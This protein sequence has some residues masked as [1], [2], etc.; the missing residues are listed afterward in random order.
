MGEA[1][2]EGEARAVG[3]GRTAG[4][5]GAGGL[6]ARAGTGE[7]IGVAAPAG[8]TR[9]AGGAELETDA[10]NVSARLE[11]VGLLGIVALA[12]VLRFVDLPTRGMWDSDQGHDMLVL[13]SWVIDGVVPLLG[14]PTSTGGIHHGALYYWLLAPAAALSRADPVA[15]TAAI[16]LFG[17]A[18]VAATWWLARTLGGPVAGLVAGVLMAV[19]PSSIEESTFIWNPTLV[20]V[21]SAIAVAA[22]WRAWTTRRARWWPVAAAGQAVA[23]QAHVLAAILLVPLVALVI[24]DLRRREPGTER[25]RAVAAAVAGLGVIALSYL[26]LLVHE[27]G[28]GFA[29]P[30]RL[31]GFAASGEGAASGD[32]APTIILRLVIVAIRSLS[33]PFT[34]LLTGAPIPA[35]LAATAIVLI[36]GWRVR[37]AVP[38]ERSA[39]VWFAATIAWSIAAL[40]VAAPSLATI[41]PG[42]PN[43]HYHAFL[44]TIVFAIAGL[45]AASVWRRG[46]AGRAVAATGV[47]LGV[48]FGVA[49]LPP[50]IAPDGGW[51]AAERAAAEVLDAVGPR[52]YVVVGL[53]GFKPADALVFPLTRAGMPPV[54]VGQPSAGQSHVGL[55]VVCDRLFEG[56]L[57]ARCGGEAEDA[58]ALEAGFTTSARRIAVSDRT[59]V[60]VY[61]PAP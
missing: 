23:M 57:G 16:A 7:A 13:R 36:L 17:V 44:D 31:I 5:G 45:G 20:P 42:L 59:S 19:S 51:P 39:A 58:L 55:V 38:P 40:V 30:Q 46:T 29:E 41:V 35:L 56:V 21:A 18:A 43:D 33:W 8:P 1:R 60:S 15:V 14:P 34:G 4:T 11:W 25:R 10:A 53:P 54:A 50:R 2:A 61:L 22:A 9:A 47:L 12:A 37:A 3:E 6:A 49:N 26:P 28:H 32:G 48:V 27:L 52:D 24:A